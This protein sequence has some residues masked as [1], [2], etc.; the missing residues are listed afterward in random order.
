MSK[1]KVRA[2][3]T[4]LAVLILIAIVVGTGVM[5][6]LLT[7]GFFG[8]G[9]GRASFTVSGTGQGSP[10]G[11]TA[12]LTLVVQNT[13]DGTGAITT[14][15][16]EGLGATPGTISVIGAPGVSGVSGTPPTT[17]SATGG[18]TIPGR[19]THQITI[20]LSSGSGLYPGARLRVYV[21]YYDLASK[22]TGIATAIVTLK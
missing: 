12:T 16:I 8:G 22:A 21:A 13:G 10:D 15:Y 4:M 20:R 2:V 6:W 14:I 7:T 3:S 1:K 18:Y 11:T 19:I 9:G 17:L 5:L